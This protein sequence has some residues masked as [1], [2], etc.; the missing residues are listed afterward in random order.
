MQCQV[1]SL[2]RALPK[3]LTPSVVLLSLSACAPA[4]QEVSGGGAAPTEAV[5]A[6]VGAEALFG[7]R[8]T[9]PGTDATVR[10][11][12]PFLRGERVAFEFLRD[13][14]TLRL[15]SSGLVVRAE[16]RAFVVLP[17][18]VRRVSGVGGLY[19]A[20][21]GVGDE[22]AVH[23]S[24]QPLGR[25][26]RLIGLEVSGGLISAL[27][28]DARLGRFPATTPNAGGVTRFKVQGDLLVKQP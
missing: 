17:L 26:V 28:V 16:G 18:E 10:I 3:W 27:T 21:L 24:S 20:L 14:G 19:L 5:H 13:R 12:A 4:A 1:F 9:V 15:L 2:K 25:G 23:R 7:T 8:L 11:E 6:D 22:G